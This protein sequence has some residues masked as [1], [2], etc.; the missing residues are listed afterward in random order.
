M[1]T[2]SNQSQ[3]S[4]TT[5]PRAQFN[6]AEL[7]DLRAQYEQ[8]LRVNMTLKNAIKC[9]AFKISTVLEDNKITTT[10][11]IVLHDSLRQVLDKT[12]PKNPASRSTRMTAEEAEVPRAVANHMNMSMSQLV[13][14]VE[15]VVHG[16]DIEEEPAATGL[17]ERQTSEGLS[18]V[19]SPAFISRQPRDDAEQNADYYPPTPMQNGSNSVLSSVLDVLLQDPDV[20]TT[21]LR[22]LVPE[23]PELLNL[24]E[25]ANAVRSLGDH[26]PADAES[27]GTFAAAPFLEDMHLRRP[28][29]SSIPDPNRPH[30]CD[31][32][33]A[34]MQMPGPM[35]SH[36]V[37]LSSSD[38]VSRLT[39]ADGAFDAAL[40]KSPLQSLT[41]K[42]RPAEKAH[43]PGPIFRAPDVQPLPPGPVKS[44]PKQSR[45]VQAASAVAMGGQSE[46]RRQPA[47]R[48]PLPA[49]ALVPGA[50]T[51]GAITAG[52]SV[53][54]AIRA[55]ASV[56]GGTSMAA[57]ASLAASGS[58]RKSKR[59]SGISVLRD[60]PEDV[61]TLIVRNIP[62]RCT[63]EQLLK[64]WPPAGSYNV[65][66]LPFS[67]IQHR[68]VDYAFINF[69]SKQALHQFCDRWEGVSLMPHISSKRLEIKLA[70]VQGYERNLVEF[71]RNRKIRETKCDWYL[72]VIIHP[73]GS[74]ADFRK[75]MA[76]MDASGISAVADNAST[77]RATATDDSS[78][79]QSQGRTPDNDE[80]AELQE[81]EEY[82]IQRVSASAS[83]GEFSAGSMMVGFR[84]APGRHD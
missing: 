36:S 22:E 59:S 82:N 7:F 66:Y 49:G 3:S 68:R 23:L 30:Q 17:L 62:S 77:A 54:G 45:D 76:A 26:T 33:P 75:V 8:E 32:S 60:I 13:D 41:S 79:D 16:I 24:S 37:P 53:P 28:G 29:R 12:Y 11:N 39:E 5:W 2:S 50:I 46:T 31:S 42:L 63:Q 58:E 25:Y 56:P 9:F 35:V 10:D 65:L 70:D 14:L 84:H 55:G 73:D 1:R 4:S 34:M 80:E 47:N 20:D 69:I 83:T 81:D 48:L 44:S 38:P 51:P 72:P 74:I 78:C 67:P 64:I 15:K 21:T 61:R 40:L 43:T 52:A 57:A 19:A 27:V 71:R 18:S 6:R